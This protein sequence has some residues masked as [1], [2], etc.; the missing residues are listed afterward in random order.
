MKCIE[1][2]KA[3]FTEPDGETRSMLLLN[4]LNKEVK[5]SVKNTGFRKI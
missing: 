3:I 2:L 1:G 4:L 5:Q